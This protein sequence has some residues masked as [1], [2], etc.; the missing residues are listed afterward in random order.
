MA[1]GDLGDITVSSWEEFLEA[2]QTWYD[3]DS[4]DTVYCPEEAVWDGNDFAPEGYTGN[5]TIYCLNINGRGT[6]IRNWHMY[7]V[8]TSYLPGTLRYIFNLHILDF[9]A[10]GVPQRNGFIHGNVLSRGC[11]FSGLLNTNYRCFI[12]N[13]QASLSTEPWMLRC[14]VNFDFQSSAGCAPVGNTTVSGGEAAYRYCRI[15]VH[16]NA[17]TGAIVDLGKVSYCDVAIYQ[18]NCSGIKFVSKNYTGCIVHGN[19]Q[20]ISTV[21]SWTG[22]WSGMMSVYEIESFPV[23]YTPKDTNNFQGLTEEQIKNP[24]VLAAR[25]FPIVPIS[26]V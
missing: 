22:T 20:E 15:E 21:E 13:P 14:S 19:L 3:G 7:G 18:P 8:I 17:V 5:I 24:T 25:G 11:K 23:G 1:L 12:D 16:G 2:I 6:E 26:G 10:D 9:V 4:Y